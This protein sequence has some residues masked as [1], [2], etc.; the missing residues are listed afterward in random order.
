LTQDG[1]SPFILALLNS[2]AAEVAEPIIAINQFMK[3]HVHELN[4]IVSGIFESKDTLV[5]KTASLFIT[6]SQ[7]TQYYTYEFTGVAL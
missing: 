5:C 7:S 1:T 2:F 6:P 4:H 3:I